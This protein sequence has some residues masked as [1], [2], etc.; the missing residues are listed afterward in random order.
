MKVIGTSYCCFLILTSALFATVL[1]IEANAQVSRDLNNV[2]RRVDD[3]NKQR[4]QAERDEMNNDLR[5]KKLSTEELKRI[6]AL[7][8]QIKE[9]LES[10]QNE[11]NAVVVKLKASEPISAKAAAETAGRINV[12]AERLLK[13]L[14]LPASKNTSTTQRNSSDENTKRL[15]LGLCTYLL[16]FIT[17]PMFESPSVLDLESAGKARLDLEEVIRRSDRIRHLG[18]PDQPST[19][20]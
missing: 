3:F 11:Y 10:L 14:N 9:D 8:A 1:S 17:S 15:L 2:G 12:R 16:K 19:N 13:N 20:L 7:K 18:E 4:S 6:A 5:G